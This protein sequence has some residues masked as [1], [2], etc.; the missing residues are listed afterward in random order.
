MWEPD[1]WQQWAPML[2]C[3]ARVCRPG[4][5]E[6]PYK[7]LTFKEHCRNLLLREGLEYDLYDGENYKAEAYGKNHWEHGPDV[8]ELLRR[9]TQADDRAPRDAINAKEQC[10]GVNRFRNNQVALFVISTFWRL[11]AGFAA[12]NIGMC[13]PGIQ[14]KLKDLADLPVTLTVASAEAGD[15][16]GVMGLVRSASHLFSLIMGRVVGSNGW[17]QF[18]AYTIFCGPPLIF[19]TPNIADNRNL[20]ILI[21]QN[22]TVNLDL[23]ADPELLISYSDLRLRV[24]NDPVGQCLIVEVLLRMFVLH[25]LGARADC[26]AQPQGNFVQPQE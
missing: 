3:Y 22:E 4:L 10:F 1:F 16:D 8:Q 13:I 25:L 20:L 18:S 7:Q 21:T 23:D 17:H 14:S 5:Y 24:V 9:A 12:V 2:W 11:M 26:V 6:A 19:C 15:D